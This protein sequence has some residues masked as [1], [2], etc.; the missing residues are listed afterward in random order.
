[1]GK[2]RA[3]R[4]R[5]EVDP[6]STYGLHMRGMDPPGQD[7]GGL[8]LGGLDLPDGVRALVR[9][10]RLARRRRIGPTHARRP[11]RSLWRRAVLVV[12][13][14]GAMTL[15]SGLGMVMAWVGRLA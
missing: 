8:N 2:I 12:C 6:G 7:L 10:Q 4:G 14:L 15:A 5:D 3:V 1:M 9:E 13:V 11:C